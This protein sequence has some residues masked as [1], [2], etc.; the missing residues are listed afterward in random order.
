MYTEIHG[1]GKALVLL[2]GGFGAI[3][4][5]EQL[6]PRLAET[7]QVIAVELQAHGHTPD[8]DRPLS[9][10]FMADDVAA[11]IKHLGLANADILGYSVGGGVALQTAI[12]H[13]GLVRK[14]VAVSTPCKSD[15][16]YPEVLAG[17][18]S[19]NA[20]VAKTWVGSPMHQAYVSVAPKPE[21]WTRLATK[22]GQSKIATDPGAAPLRR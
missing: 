19:I 12:R 14:L 7:R 11:L 9:F 8:I 4:T 16:W 21:D 17:M 2:H 3:G 13:P 1:A 15:G 6:L 20:E 18:R 10:E 22:M 5:F